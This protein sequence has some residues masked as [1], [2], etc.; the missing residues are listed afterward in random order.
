VFIR[1]NIRN[2]LDLKVSKIFQ[3]EGRSSVGKQGV[4]FAFLMR[5]EGLNV[6]TL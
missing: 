3:E 4:N 5:C 2:C 1:A 6:L